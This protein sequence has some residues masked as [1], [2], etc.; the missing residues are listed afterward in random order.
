MPLHTDPIPPLSLPANAEN[1]GNHSD[2]HAVRVPNIQYRTA[3]ENKGATKPSST[4]RVYEAMPPGVQLGNA[5]HKEEMT[6]E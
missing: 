3:R 6:M 2:L 1:W 4:G 5:D